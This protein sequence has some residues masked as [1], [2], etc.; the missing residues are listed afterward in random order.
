MTYD[1]VFNNHFLTDGREKF[2]WL[3]HT[4]QELLFDLEN[5]PQ[6]MHNL[7]T[8]SNE[9]R[10]KVWRDRMVDELKDRPEGFVEGGKLVAGKTHV[11]IP[12][13]V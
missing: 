1:D 4:G 7:A 9:S 11:P 2:I 3:S 12:P 13:S 10:V 6:E 8:D 5:D